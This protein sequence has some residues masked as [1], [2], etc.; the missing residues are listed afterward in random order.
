MNEI[1]YEFSLYISVRYICPIH[2]RIP[3]IRLQGH[4]FHDASS[5]HSTLISKKIIS[6]R[7]LC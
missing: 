5:V 1:K 4:L 6:Q 7:K 2:L 3:A